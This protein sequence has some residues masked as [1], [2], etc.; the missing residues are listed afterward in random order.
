MARVMKTRAVTLSHELSKSLEF[1]L[2]EISSV[3]RLRINIITTTTFGLIR[4]LTFE[5]SIFSPSK[6][7]LNWS[8]VHDQV[9]SVPVSLQNPAHAQHDTKGYFCSYTNDLVVGGRM[10]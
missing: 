10:S 1:N 3:K 6:A 5:D 7:P 8:A 9:A 2:K 4:Q